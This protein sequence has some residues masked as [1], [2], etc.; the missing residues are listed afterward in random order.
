MLKLYYSPGSCALA[1]HIA[2]EEAGCAYTAE[3]LDFKRNQQTSPEYLAINPK[4]RVPAL[5]TDR[6]ILT[7]TPAILAFIAQSFPQA[8]LAPADPFAFAQAQAF[9]LY[10]CSTVHVAHAH[11]GRG[12]RW[13]NDESSFADMKRKVP[14][15]MAACFALIERNLSTGPWVMGE[16][17][18]ICDPYLFTLAGW[19]EGDGVD[20]ATLPKVADHHRRMKERPAV[21]KVLA[22]ELS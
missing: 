11:K 6:G 16:S 1:S 9:N 2:L 14:E 7:E 4:G 15:T 20:I 18:T 8:K 21:K 19:L 3:R 10:L 12:H 22:E 17:F 13:A 5:V